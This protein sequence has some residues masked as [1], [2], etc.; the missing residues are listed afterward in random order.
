MEIVDNAI[1]LFIPG[2]MDAG[3]DD[4]LFW[5]SLSFALSVAGFVAY[6]GQPLA[7]PAREG[8]RRSARDRASTAAPRPRVVGAIARPRGSSATVVLIAEA[9]G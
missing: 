5:G 4:V 1:M 2:A 6:P 7:A 8:P 9:L 3:L